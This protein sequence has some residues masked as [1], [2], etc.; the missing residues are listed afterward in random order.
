MAQNTVRSIP[1]EGK[2][3]AQ[4][5]RLRGRIKEF[6]QETYQLRDFAWLPK[7]ILE[8]VNEDMPGGSVNREV[9]IA[10][11][12]IHYSLLYRTGGEKAMNMFEAMMRAQKLKPH[13]N[14]YNP[15]VEHL[16][17][18]S[19][20]AEKSAAM[21]ILMDYSCAEVWGRTLQSEKKEVEKIERDEK[22]KQIKFEEEY[23]ELDEQ[24]PL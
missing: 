7:K 6:E 20:C 21:T 11:T 3:T 16:N 1:V 10:F 2:V 22:Y 17:S 18:I 4:M 14:T 5:S 24:Y 8:K 12:D 9:L 19:K 23:V 15:N 13:G